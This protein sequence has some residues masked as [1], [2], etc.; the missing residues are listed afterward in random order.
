MISYMALRINQAIISG[1]IDNR[2]PGVTHGGIELLGMQRPLQLI[3]KGNC[4]RDLAGTRL[5]F[6]NPNPQPQHDVIEELHFLHRGVV[7]D[8]TA[9]EK[10]KSL[11]IPQE[12]IA[13]YLEEGKQ[14]PFE[15]KNCLSL[16]WYSLANGRVMIEATG[17]ELKLSHHM[18]ELDVEGEKQQQ[19]D[20]SVVLEH[21]IHLINEA[22]EAE[23]YVSDESDEDA[24]EFE[25]ERRL[26]VRDTL[27]EAVEFLSQSDVDDGGD[28]DL[29][30][31]NSML[32]R[33][34]IVQTAFKFQMD[35]MM[36]LGSSFLDSGSRGELAM[37]A[38]FV[39]ET[40][41]EICPE[42]LEK[43][44]E[45]ERGYKIAMLKRA[46]DAGNLAI[47]SCNILELEDDGFKQ[48]RD[49]FFELRDMVLDRLRL[50]R[51]RE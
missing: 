50:L 32:E 17:F 10:V 18:W 48:I 16:E 19:E 8:M 24:D 46:T 22:N 43:E 2:M 39:F 41:D 34:L 21:F 11:L 31:A 38:R 33:E 12:E 45:M 26:R 20:N 40:L 47:A 35:V 49:Q 51:N 14:I 25:W 36:Y 13:E 7:G 3:L 23:S 5:D 9:S 37:A 30:D 27:D 4:A 6:V 44:Q 29:L 15:W 42:M 1:W 28:D